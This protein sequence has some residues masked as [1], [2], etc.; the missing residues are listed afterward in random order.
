MRWVTFVSSPKNVSRTYSNTLPI[1][2][3]GFGTPR[4]SGFGRPGSPICACALAGTTSSATSVEPDAPRAAAGHQAAI[5][6]DSSTM[7]SPSATKPS[8]RPARASP[9]WKRIPPHTSP[10]TLNAAPIGIVV[11]HA[12]DEL[13]EAREPAA[14]RLA[15]RRALQRRPSDIRHRQVDDQHCEQ[16]RRDRNAQDGRSGRGSS[17]IPGPPVGSHELGRRS[18]RDRR[19][20]GTGAA[21]RAAGGITGCGSGVAV[22]AGAAAGGADRR[23]AVGAFGRSRRVAARLRSRPRAR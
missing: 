5:G 6:F 2:S 19:G 13:H 18:G 11:G 3:T 14:A 12:V 8:T 20:R 15:A 16:G 1:S 4:S 7:P 9:A 17:A 23:D 22:A 21:G 10:S